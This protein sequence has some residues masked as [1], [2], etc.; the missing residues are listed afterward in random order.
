M[1]FPRILYAGFPATGSVI[2]HF[3][4]LEYAIRKILSQVPFCGIRREH[5]AFIRERTRLFRCCFPSRQR[6]KLGLSG[7]EQLPGGAVIL[8]FPLFCG[9]KTGTAAGG[10]SEAAF[11][12]P[13]K[14]GQVWEPCHRG[15][16]CHAVALA[17]KAFCLVQTQFRQVRFGRL[18]IRLAEKGC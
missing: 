1:A 10:A 17:E 9:R 5:R 15:R 4:T 2:A 12:L 7:Q 16:L 18:S 8:S 13:G 3:F 14:I 11:I 6:G